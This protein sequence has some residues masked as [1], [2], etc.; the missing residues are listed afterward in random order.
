MG[1]ASFRSGRAGVVSVAVL[2]AAAAGP[3]CSGSGSGSSR[4]ADG[5]LG[6]G[7]GGG[8]GSLLGGP[9]NGGLGP[10]GGPCEGLECAIHSCAVGSTTISGTVYDPAGKNPLYGVAVFV[11]NATPA[12]L[13]PGIDATSCSCSALYTGQPVASAITDAAGSFTIQNAPDGTNIPLVVQIGKWRRQLTIPRVTACLDN[14]QADH[15]LRLPR[16]QS[17]GDIP[18][19]AVSTGGADT[20]ECLLRRVGVDAVEYCGGAGGPG[21][22]H[23]FQGGKDPMFTPNTS[24]PGPGS[25]TSL[26]DSAGD[27]N[28]YDI[29]L[30][31]CEGAETQNPSPANVYAYVNGGGRVF[32]EH[33]HYAFFTQTLSGGSGSPPFPMTLAAWTPD[34]SGADE[35]PGAIGAAIETGFPK[36]AALKTWLGNVNAL[37]GDELPIAVARHNALV[38]A[39]NA[40]STAWI[41]SGAGASPASTQYLSFDMP[42]DL[43]NAADGGAGRSQACGRVVYSDLHV[44]AA[45]NDY[46]TGGKKGVPMITPDGCSTADLSADEKALEFMLFDLSACV[47]PIGS[48]PQA[49]PASGPPPR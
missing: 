23:I 15:T 29:V 18:S 35:Y 19:I 8:P 12:P 17:E 34:N 9:S 30:L 13:T 40:P 1:I 36:G 24:P 43:A 14:A 20:L 38:A 39:A 2:L 4:Q 42:F 33:Y 46:P 7:S 5:G 49:P 27:L 3:G 26:W 10:D 31:S 41:Q 48:A 22:I 6:S 44:G 28:E 16:N 25:A 45:A 11:P 47:T 37:V 21:R 32:A